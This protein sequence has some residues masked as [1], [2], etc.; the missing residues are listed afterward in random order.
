MAYVSIVLGVYNGENF[1]REAVDSILSQTFRDF[2]LIISD[3]ASTDG[4]AN[5]CKE[6]AERNKCVRYYRN[7]ENLGAVYNFNHLFQLATGKY[8]KWASHDDVCA[9]TLVER[10]V[11]ILDQEP[12]VVLCYAKTTFIDENSQKIGEY[13]DKLNLCSPKPHIRFREFL[14]KPPGCNPVFGLMRRNVL[15]TTQLFGSFE[16]ADYILLAKMCFRGQFWEVPEHLFYRRNHPLTSRRANKTN[17]DFIRW[18]G[19][20]RCSSYSIP[21]LKI[22]N[23]LIKSVKHAPIDDY[24]KLLCYGEIIRSTLTLSKRT[25]EWIRARKDP[26]RMY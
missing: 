4:T 17:H 13:E 6:Y 19:M 2:E 16:S 22:L 7:K 10:C 20:R 1:I 15:A 26:K 24:E 25:I 3:N 14:C 8:F 11:D 23:E 21:Y 18:L 9:P 12:D 5:I